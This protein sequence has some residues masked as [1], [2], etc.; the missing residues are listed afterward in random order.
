M[1]DE[2]VEINDDFDSPFE[3]EMQEDEDEAE[4]EA[5]AGILNA[6]NRLSFRQRKFVSFYVEDQYG[7]AECAKLAGYGRPW[8]L[9]GARL[10]NNPKVVDAIHARRIEQARAASI[11]VEQVLCEMAEL[12]FFDMGKF[13]GTDA[14]GRP[15]LDIEGLSKQHGKA[16]QSI[17]TRE[18]GSGFEV[19]VAMVDKNK[20][21]ET[22][23]RH[24][25]MLVE[26]HE[27]KGNVTV[28]TED[29]SAD[30]RVRRIQEILVGEIVEGQVVALEAK[31]VGDCT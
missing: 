7:V 11:N 31:G 15:T 20:A 2:F 12:A 14:K 16:I 17:T 10:L 30:E 26:R 29:M 8:K 27:L 22:L 25:G 18:R 23:A 28:T 13:T 9:V 5:A 1:V 3:Q 24:L 6:E 21:I 4:M 19:R